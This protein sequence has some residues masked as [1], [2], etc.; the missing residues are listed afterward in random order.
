MDQTGEAEA[1]ARTSPQHAAVCFGRASRALAQKNRTRPKNIIRAGARPA[2]AGSPDDPTFARFDELHDLGDL[3]V[4]RQ[5]FS[6][7]FQRLL[8]VEFRAI[9]ETKSFLDPLHALR[10]KLF[11]LQPDE[12]NS[13]DFRW[14]AVGDHKWRNV[15]H[16]FGTT[17]RDGEAPDAAKLM[18]GSETAHHR[19]IAHLDVARERSIVRK[20]NVIADR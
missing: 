5:I 10:R 16:D 13:A 3:F 15:L 14:I 18:H 8:R 6:D 12:I 2:L 20:D 11:S 1:R 17:A 19:V 4:L 7:R 9:N